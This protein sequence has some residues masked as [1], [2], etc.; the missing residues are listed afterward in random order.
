MQSSPLEGLSVLVLDDEALW[1][2]HV[3]T[4]FARW[5]HRQ[6]PR[7]AQPLVEVSAASLT[8]P[9]AAHELFGR[10]RGQ[11]GPGAGARMGLFEAAHGGSL[12]LDELA[13]LPAAL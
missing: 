5:L 12:F 9:F 2:E 3:A 4:S 1:R 8:G 11:G 6:G 7:V 10:E 13:C